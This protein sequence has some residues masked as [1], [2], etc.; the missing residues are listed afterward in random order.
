MSDQRPDR[1]GFR[2]GFW[3]GTTFSG[4]AGTALW[5]HAGGRSL[6][7]LL[8]GGLALVLGLLP[9]M[10]RLADEEDDADEGK[11]GPPGSGA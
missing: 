3:I 5:L 7:A 6:L 9:F 2:V 8:P 4:M 1:F 11:K 10:S